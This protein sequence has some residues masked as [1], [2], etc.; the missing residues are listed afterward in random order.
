ML[1]VQIIVI[2]V[3]ETNLIC[4]GVKYSILKKKKK[5]VK[6]FQGLR[7]LSTR[8]VF[9]AVNVTPNTSFS[10]LFSLIVKPQELALL[11]LYRRNSILLCMIWYSREKN[12]STS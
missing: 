1:N 11:P 7:Q 9:N 4:L 5:G 10:F 12:S 6:Y 8:V 3:E 2:D